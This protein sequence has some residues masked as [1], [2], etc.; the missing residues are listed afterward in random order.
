MHELILLG[1]NLI[2]STLPAPQPGKSPGLFCGTIVTGIRIGPNAAELKKMVSESIEESTA[3]IE[4]L[5]KD[6]TPAQEKFRESF[7]DLK[8]RDARAYVS[9][10]LAF[11]FLAARYAGV[12]VSIVGKILTERGTRD[13]AALKLPP[14]IEPIARGLS[15]STEDLSLESRLASTLLMLEL[16]LA[17]DF[18][19]NV[20]PQ[21]PPPRVYRRIETYLMFL[22]DQKD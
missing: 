18:D 10:E 17:R 5:L 1:L 21:L 9:E 2:V 4:A 7:D 13:Y 20:D 8:R 16:A 22:T 14:N 11:S 19:L 12:D 15:V 6:S 3:R